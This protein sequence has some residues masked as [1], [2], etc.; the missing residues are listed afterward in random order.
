MDDILKIVVAL[1]RENEGQRAPEF[2]KQLIEKLHEVASLYTSIE[3]LDSLIKAEDQ[4]GV[5]K[6]ARCMDQAMEDYEQRRKEKTARLIR[7]RERVADEA[8]DPE[9]WQQAKDQLQQ[10]T[11]DEVVEALVRLTKLPAPVKLRTL[12]PGD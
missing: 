3:P 6:S 10:R 12:K 11:F 9:T 7:K 2:V 4:E 8:S 1:L 5:E